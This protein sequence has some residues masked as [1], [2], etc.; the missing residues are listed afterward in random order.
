LED[1]CEDAALL[2]REE[3]REDAETP[4]PVH[5]AEIKVTASASTIAKAV[6]LL[7]LISTFQTYIGINTEFKAIHIL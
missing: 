3:L 4:P 7:F 5:E 1:A 6:N 2:L